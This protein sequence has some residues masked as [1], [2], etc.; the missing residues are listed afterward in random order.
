MNSPFVLF[1]AG[2]DSGD[3]LGER[4]VVSVVARGLRACGSGGARMQAAGLEPIVPFEELPVSGF[5]DVLPRYFRLRRLYVRLVK[6]LKSPDCVGLIAIDYP[7]FNMRLNALAKRLQKRVLYVAPP[8]VWAW[9]QRRAK[10][11][12]GT[13]L[14]VLFE[15][16]RAAYKTLACQATLL[17][18]PF[19][20]D[21][22]FMPAGETSALPSTFLLP[23][24][25]KSQALRNLRLYL[26][27]A[28]QIHDAQ[29]HDAQIH[30]AQ[31]HDAL[32]TN[33][34]VVAARASLIPVFEKNMAQFFAGKIP[35]WICVKLAP[36]NIA[37]RRE[38]YASANAALA[39][40]GTVTLEL[41]LSGCPLVVATI[42]DVLTYIMGNL[43]VK[44]K[45]F[46]M[47][48]ILLKNNTSKETC[49]QKAC[50]EYVCTPW[51]WR[52]QIDEIQKALQTANKNSARQVAES[53]T[54]ILS[55]GVSAESL[56]QSFIA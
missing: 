50:E 4:F 31:I 7:G 13:D 53:L 14:A 16:E 10:E 42:P 17:R 38:F 43:F 32:Q 5:G 39:S 11:L 36:P 26:N 1:C 25:R 45:I 19:L 35:E 37:K 18:H 54:Q 56:V 3:V 41:A 29:I 40:P 6:A 21:G 30:D 9:K 23:G 22:E 28:R 48:N 15:F 55:A 12:R 52:N 44:T 46:A 8:Q 20:P 49:P 27:V 47:P 33:F 51:A 24:S 2:E 34:V